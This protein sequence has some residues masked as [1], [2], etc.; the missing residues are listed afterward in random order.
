MPTS[1]YK[2]AD[3]RKVPGVTTIIGE[4]LG[5]NK[6]QLMRWAARKERA[7]ISHEA[8]RDEKAAIGTAT[9]AV[10]E[11][12]LSEASTLHGAAVGDPAQEQ[13]IQGIMVRAI[14]QIVHT[15]P[16]WNQ[17]KVMRACVGWANWY[18]HH[19][20][21]LIA[22][23]PHLVST[24]HGF[25]GTPDLV[26]R[27]NEGKLIIVDWKTSAGIWPETAIQL[28]AYGI[29]WEEERGERVDHLFGVK[30]DRDNATWA[31][32]WVET[33][34][35]RAAETCFLDLVEIDSLKERVQAGFVM[36]NSSYMSLG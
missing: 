8:E 16:E 18:G 30:L 28:A 36:T 20:G 24:K 26:C 23:E 2:D 32:H 27:D 4:T 13:R 1:E 34:A 6:N 21:E 35:R 7:G 14:N 25:G 9:H 22:I 11:T 3:G 29:A 5:W 33:S 10:I 12:F 17:A 15:V 31:D 19:P